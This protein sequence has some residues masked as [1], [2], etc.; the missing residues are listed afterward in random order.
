MYAVQCELQQTHILCTVL[1]QDRS[2]FLT[3][4]G[5]VRLSGSGLDSVFLGVFKPVEDNET[6]MKLWATPAGVILCMDR[7]LADVLGYA[8]SDLVGTSLAKLDAKE[9]D[10]LARYAQGHGLTM[11]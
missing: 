3:N 2:V 10:S 5:V 7:R 1:L 9:H 8:A 11:S 4:L 6:D